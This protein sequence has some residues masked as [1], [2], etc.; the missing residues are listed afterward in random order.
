MGTGRSEVKE[1]GAAKP[2]P[3]DMSSARYPLALS[4]NS[5]WREGP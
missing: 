1:E 4:H 5:P 3:G 2:G